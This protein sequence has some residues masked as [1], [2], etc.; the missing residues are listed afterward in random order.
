VVRAAEGEVGVAAGDA[1]VGPELEG[2]LQ[3]LLDG[4]SAVAVVEA[5]ETGV[6]EAVT[7]EGSE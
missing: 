4:G 5:V 1:L 3:G 7:E 6:D 2:D